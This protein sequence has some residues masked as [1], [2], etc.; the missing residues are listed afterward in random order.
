MKL[1]I[2]CKLISDTKTKINSIKKTVN[3]Y[4]NVTHTYFKILSK[5]HLG[6]SKKKLMSILE[7]EKQVMKYYEGFP[8]ALRQSARDKAIESYKSWVK[9]R[10]RKPKIKP[11]IRLDKRSYTIIKTDNKEYPYFVSISTQEGRVRFPLG[12]GKQRMKYFENSKNKS[13]EIV[14]INEEYYINIVF[15]VLVKEIEKTGEFLGVDL[16]LTNIA[17]ITTAGNR[18]TEFFSGLAYKKRLTQLREQ[19]RSAK[20]RKSKNLIG[21]KIGRLNNDI[22]H[23]VS[24]KIVNNAIANKVNTIAFEELKKFN[25]KKKKMKK[26]TNYR[27]N[28]WMR[29][30]IQMYTAYKAGL[31]SVPVVTVDPKHTSQRC[32]RCNHTERKN[33]RGILFSCKHCKYT[34]NADRIGSINIAQRYL[35]VF[36]GQKLPT[37]ITHVSGWSAMTIPRGGGAANFV[38]SNEAYLFKGT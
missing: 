27:L 21:R 25:P 26:K 10:G 28:M 32:P 30:R 6:W 14:G 38:L 36:V 5:E 23:K 20:T 29:K 22:A 18:E 31:N 13:A 4:N 8:S 33:R 1:T 7:K 34:N 37:N 12:I 2:K 24:K 17:T 3:Q 15:E 19:Y 16:G 35:G 9:T 11:S